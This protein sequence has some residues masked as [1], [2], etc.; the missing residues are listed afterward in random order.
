MDP[1]PYQLLIKL[2]SEQNNLS[3]HILGKVSIETF[4]KGNTVSYE[5]EECSKADSW[6]ANGLFFFLL[7][8]LFSYK[9]IFQHN[10]CSLQ[11]VAHVKKN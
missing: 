9:S 5:Q 6:K 8:I 2:Y 3:K 11:W 4:F 7:Q 1:V 10:Q